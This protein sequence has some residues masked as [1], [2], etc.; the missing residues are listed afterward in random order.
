MT[1][2][3]GSV[4]VM[5]IADTRAFLAVVRSL[6]RAGLQVHVVGTP[7][8]APALRS[9]YIKAIH[10]MPVYE[11]GNDRGGND[12]GVNDKWVNDKWVN[13]KWVND[14]WVSEFR[15]LLERHSFDLVVP[16]DDT[17]I[18]PLQ[19]NRAALRDVPCRIY[20]L[21]DD[22]YATTLDKQRTYALA[23]KVDIPRPRQLEAHSLEELKSAA[24]LFGFPLIIKPVS[25][26]TVA[27]LSAKRMVRPVEDERELMETG[28]E[29]IADGGVALVQE[30]FRGVGVGVEVLCRDGE[31]LVAFQHE[32]VHEPLGGGGS[33]YRKSTPLDPEML[34]ATRRLMSAM[35]YTGVCMAEFRYNH[36][37][38]SWVLIELNGRFWGSLPLAVAAGVNFPLYLYEMLCL[39]RAEFPREYK[40]GLY[41]R[42]W[43]KD[44]GW[45]VR[46]LKPASA[47]SFLASARNV[48]LL[49]ERSDTFVP[50]DVAPAWHEFR[51]LLERA[52]LATVLGTPGLRRRMRNRLTR[53]SRDCRTVLFVCKGNICRSPFAARLFA[54]RAANSVRVLSGGFLP[55]GRCTPDAAVMAARDWG[56]QMEDHRSALIT[57]SDI[58]SS[59]IVFVFDSQQVVGIRALFPSSA[60]KVVLMGAL[61]DGPVQIPDPL[62][63][64]VDGFRQV[65]A[66]I[67][68]AVSAVFAHFDSVPGS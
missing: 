15:N 63:K 31:V 65:Y 48:L 29:L 27:N 34:E 51:P 19:L 43:L 39:G 20:L 52:L 1:G 14:R 6:G 40:K 67:E 64:Q 12:R 47:A 32:R 36:A 35:Q 49:R 53:C 50:D 11:P 7:L 10:P 4:L 16:C 24:S 61:D 60:S 17:V 3:A 8:D 54:S 57:E 42:N 55:P 66:R 41:C 37:E 23:T 33:S 13:D 38:R 25:S 46:N 45:L 58:C 5:G 9:R 44:L 18:I 62:G 2:Y 21:D 68:S 56:V 22:A 30:F 28:A 26:F 59:G